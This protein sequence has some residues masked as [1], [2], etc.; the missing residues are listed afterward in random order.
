[1]VEH[2]WM[3]GVVMAFLSFGIKAGLGLGA[4]I[5]NARVSRVSAALFFLGTLA[6]YL[7]LFLALHLV[8]TRLNLIA[9]LDRI[10]H[11]IQYG[12]VIHLAVALGLFVWGTWLLLKPDAA[13]P[14][15]GVGAGLFLVLP[16]PVCATVI[17]LNLT[18]ALSLSPLPPLAIS[19]SLLGLFWGIIVLTL[20]SL[21]LCRGR[22]GVNNNFLG[23]A[24]ALISLY[25]LGTVIIAPIYPKIRPAFAMAVSNNPA[26]Q[27]D[28]TATLVLS[29]I[30]LVL[31]GIGFVRFYFFKKV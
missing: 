24:M 19:L 29:G 25:F 16:C 4:Q 17:L 2:L 22:A 18:L 8:V 31:V 12:M 28:P 5:F 10:T 15:T 9:Y 11:L 13:G 14:G 20:V 27:T 21:F 26:G 7:I 23:A 1:M 30:S 3:S 6:V